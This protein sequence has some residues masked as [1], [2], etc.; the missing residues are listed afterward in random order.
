MQLSRDQRP[1]ANLIT[2]LGDDGLRIR[3]Q[4]FTASLVVSAETIIEDWPVTGATTLRPRD[5][6]DVLALEP[7]VVQFGSGPRI[8]FPGGEAL[9]PLLE[10]GIGVEVMDTPAACRTYNLLLTEGRRVVAALLLG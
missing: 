8:E 6:D 5:W 9:A 7:E 3:E 1:D 10:R 2:A 4:R